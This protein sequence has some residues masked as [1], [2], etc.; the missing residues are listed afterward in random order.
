VEFDAW[1]EI[2]AVEV[3]IDGMRDLPPM[4]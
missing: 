1:T 2:L 3:A 4:G